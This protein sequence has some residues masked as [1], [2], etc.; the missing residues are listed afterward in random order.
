MK[1]GLSK[2]LTAVAG[3][4]RVGRRGLVAR[5]DEMEILREELIKE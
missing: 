2:V 4:R 5:N 1:T 3:S